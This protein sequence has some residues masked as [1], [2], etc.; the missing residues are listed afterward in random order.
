MSVWG[1]DIKPFEWEKLNG[2][3]LR[4]IVGEQDGSVAVLGYDEENKVAYVLHN[5]ISEEPIR[6][7]VKKYYE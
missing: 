5:E 7:R 6:E 3:N 4:I 1:K 2:K